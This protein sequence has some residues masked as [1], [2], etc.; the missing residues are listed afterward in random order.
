MEESTDP[1]KRGSDPNTAAYG[2]V[3]VPQSR[4]SD[5][6]AW[7]MEHQAAKSS[8]YALDTKIVPLTGGAASDYQEYALHGNSYWAVKA[9]A[10]AMHN[11]I[12]V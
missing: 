4:G 12:S 5:V 11:A 9:G 6:L 7:V 1:Y 8:G 10:F 2:R 3:Y